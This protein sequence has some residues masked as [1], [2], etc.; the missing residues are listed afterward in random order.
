MEILGRIKG[1]DDLKKLRTRDLGKLA[2]EI[3][4]AIVDAVSKNGGHL[5]SNLGI[6]E[7][8]IALHKIFDSPKDRIIFDVGH[9]CYA[10]KI[11]T[12]RLNRFGSIRKKGGLSGFPNPD[13]SRHDLYKTG[14]ASTAVSLAAGEAIARDLKGEKHSVIAIVGDGSL[15]GGECF[16]AL[17]HIGQMDTDVLVILNDNQM[18][19]SPSVGALSLFTSKLRAAIFYRRFSHYVGKGF[20]RMGRFGEWA[21]GMG[22]RIKGAL[23]RFLMADQYFEQLGFRYL[24]PVDGHDIPL[25]LAFLGRIKHMKGPVLLHVVTKKGKGCSFAESKP[26]EYHGTA[27]FKPANGETA[28][29]KP[30]YSKIFGEC[31]VEAAKKDKSIVTITAAMSDG[32]GLAEFQRIFPGRLFDV[33][34]AEQHAVSLASAFA[35]N[36][37]KPVVAIYSTFLQRAYDQ[38][39]H[40]VALMNLP[41]IFAIDRAGLVP[42]DG[43]TH[44][45]IFDLAYLS[46]VPNITVMAPSC[47]KELCQMLEI[48]FSSKGPS[49][50]RYPK[51]AALKADCEDVVF[52]KAELV[53]NGSDILLAYIGTFRQETATISEMLEKDGFSCAVLNM[54]FASPLDTGSMLKHAEGK[55]LVF[56][57]EEGVTGGGIGQRLMEHIPSLHIIGLPNTFPENGSRKELLESQKLDT[58]SI[59]EKI[60]A[61]LS[62]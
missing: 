19:I 15:T 5:A 47:A 53:K 21:V 14:H 48:A 39:I 8:T 9:Q 46:L 18:S 51:D 10:H 56:F 20:S 6:V 52:G 27:P 36:G 11:I 54:R 28:N 59:Y 38:I 31:M 40:D 4:E 3:R 49:A 41:V 2:C 37:L 62:K 16:E 58:I 55:K 61:S 22:F 26:T 32:T 50:I 57:I 25:L 13:E 23:K 43:P 45:G 33:G 7:L 29:G 44:Q 1:P 34:I 60:K 24:G 35:R 12:G 30:T 17:N 42:D